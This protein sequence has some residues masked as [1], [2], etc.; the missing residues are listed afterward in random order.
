MGALGNLFPLIVLFVVVCG[1]G[2][3]GYQVRAGNAGFSGGL[4]SCSGLRWQ[5]R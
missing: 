1:V 2:Y 4:F 3:I 5:F